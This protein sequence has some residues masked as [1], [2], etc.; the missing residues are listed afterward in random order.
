MFLLIAFAF[1]AGIVT[2]LS[3]CI[4]PVLPIIL[5]SSIGAVE[6][7]KG[8]AFGVVTGFV[9]SFTFFTLFLSTIVSIS[10]IPSESL[11]IFAIVILI[12]FGLAL[13]IPKFQYW[14]EIL[15][16]KLSSFLPQSNQQTGFWGGIIIGLTLGLLWTPC[17]G[18][19]LASVI[20]LAVTGKVTLDTF[21]ITFAYALGTAIP[22][23]FIILGGQKVLQKV[24]WLLRNTAN[25]QKV[26]GV[27]MIL[28]ALAIF[29][30][31]DRKFQ[32]F[33]LNT[34][35][36]YGTGLTKIEDIP[37]VRNSL[38]ALYGKSMP[39]ENM[40]K[41]SFEL[42]DPKGPP[43]PELI[44]GGEWFNSSPLKLSDLKGKVVLI[45]FWT[46]SCINCQR[47]LP[48]LISWNQKYADK[49]LV[50]IGV[51]APEFE[52]EKNPENVKKALKD[53]GIKYPVMQDNNFATWRAY[54][55]QYW[56]AKYLI[57][58]DGNIR[59]THFGEGE[60]DETEKAIQQLL[61]ENGAD[62]SAEKV[63]NPEYQIYSQ[64]PET[65]LGWGRMEYLA[66]PDTVVKDAS[67]L[68]KAPDN[69]PSNTFAFI[70]D[71]DVMK[72]YS[73]ASSNAQLVL[74]FSAKEVYLVM[75]PRDGKT[76]G[77]VRVYLDDK[78]VSDIGVAG[79]SVNNNEVTVSSDDLYKLINL[80]TPGR[81][82]LRLEFLDPGTE[83]FA[84]TF[85]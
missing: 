36:N 66:S 4:L 56:P 29:F 60:Y 55:N 46:Y 44:P 20:A 53:F 25:I 15:F 57:D 59:F 30:N 81:H 37:I 77:K 11:R 40:G 49:G 41:P 1:L 52:F 3:P 47:T 83:V 42:T 84:F 82:I 33:I 48:Y 70:G 6:I 5:T 69:L 85:G 13:L 12:L 65:Y 2:I 19:I 80:P 61:Q 62:V 16:S 38:N 35:P 34:F 9:L 67:S 31:F 63:N 26:F 18:P 54:S 68:Y 64:T 28:T 51:H 72:E 21:L 71:W 50:I 43:A 45:D 58:K 24:P 74:N 39:T 8:R 27:I 22:M 78:L 17:V 10:G 7:G 76:P 79:A 14:M 73:H 75:R 32:T 23:F